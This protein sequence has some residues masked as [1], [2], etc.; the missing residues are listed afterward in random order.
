MPDYFSGKTILITGASSGIGKALA[1]N[2]AGRNITLILTAR[3]T[4]ELKQ[5]WDTMEQAEK[6]KNLQAVWRNKAIADTYEPG[7]VFKL[8]TSSA[9]LEEGITDTD[10]EGEFC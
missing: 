9:A 4:E 3:R 7:S 8:I 10:K 2:I 1:E 6:T 5:S